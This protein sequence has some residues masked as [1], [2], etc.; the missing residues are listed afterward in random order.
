MTD[1]SK[2]IFCRIVH[3]E[4]PSFQVCE[5]ELTLTFMD[6][7]PV[8]PGHSLVIPKEHYENIFE[9]PPDTLAAIACS[10]RRLALAIRSELQPEGLGLFQLNGA[11]AGQTVFH[12]HQHLI[13]RSS[14][15]TLKLHTRVR[16][17]D[18]EL[19]AVSVR[20]ARKLAAAL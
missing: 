14:G 8:A 6:I 2:C 9:V 19:L 15:E 1:H 5:D 11:A 17:D 20:L 13:P 16:G 3:E 4:V 10:S 18:D 12:Y 7:F